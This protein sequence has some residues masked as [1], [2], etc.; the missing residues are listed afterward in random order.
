[1]NDASP[2]HAVIILAA[3]ASRRMGTPKQLL[4]IDGERLINRV[5]RLAKTT[6]PSQILLV[7]G[8]H[9]DEIA[10]AIQYLDVERVDCADWQRGMSASLQAG[11]N[12]VNPRCDGALIMLCD[13]PDV[14]DI[15]LNA[16]LN[17]WHH[18]PDHAVASGYEGTLGVPALLPRNWFAKIHT[19]Q[20]DQG[21]RELLRT[22]PA[23]IAIKT[24]ALAR[25]ID[26]PQ[27][28]QGDFP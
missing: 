13:Q 16:M 18:H 17:R 12:H 22:N 19:L 23:V 6:A 26:F 27:D 9:A 2:Q 21:A 11:I 20:G 7:L 25:D 5:I 10:A 4:F 3:G 24:G 1:M 8:H 15:H 14:T 28:I